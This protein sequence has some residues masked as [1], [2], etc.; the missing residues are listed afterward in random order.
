VVTSADEARHRAAKA[1]AL[2][3]L[4]NGA[5]AAQLVK[6]SDAGETSA[7]I[8]FAP[9]RV[10]A[11]SNARPAAAACPGR[12]RAHFTSRSGSETRRAWIGSPR[13]QQSKS[14]ASA[15]AVP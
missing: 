10:P 2:L 15:A 7:R 14:S 4:V 5:P 12:R 1:T 11:S 9:I 6:A 3:R 13:S 8:D